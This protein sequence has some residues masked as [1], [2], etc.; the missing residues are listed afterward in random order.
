M[1]RVQIAASAI[2]RAG[3]ESLL[4]TSPEI[5]VVAGGA[6]VVIAEEEPPPTPA[7]TSAGMRKTSRSVAAPARNWRK[8]TVPPPAVCKPSVPLNERRSRDGV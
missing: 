7:E 3:I 6:D 2:T 5:E 1:I 4:R 8:P